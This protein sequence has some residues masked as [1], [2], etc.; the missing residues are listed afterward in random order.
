MQHF[1]TL[2]LRVSLFYVLYYSPRE[3][4][5]RGLGALTISSSTL[6]TR[7]TYAIKTDGQVFYCAGLPTNVISYKTIFRIN[8]LLIKYLVL[9]SWSS[10]SGGWTDQTCLSI[11]QFLYL[12]FINLIMANAPFS[13]PLKTSES[14][15]RG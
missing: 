10:S 8:W 15:E 1:A 13:Y 4:L 5:G 2:V 6:L 14:R 12:I 3:G 9:A 11:L 7:L